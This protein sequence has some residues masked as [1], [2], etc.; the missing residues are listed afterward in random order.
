MRIISLI[1][2]IFAVI[3]IFFSCARETDQKVFVLFLVDTMRYDIFMEIA[4]NEYDESGFSYLYKNGSSFPLAFAPSPWT[5]PSFYSIFTA[6]PPHE[7]PSIT[8][9]GPASL[10]FFTD[11]LKNYGIKTAGFGSSPYF[12]TFF[13]FDK[14]FDVFHNI[15]KT[16]QSDTALRKVAPDTFFYAL[17]NAEE[18]KN[19]VFD[20]LK[21]Y[22]DKDCL[23]LFIHFIDP[24]I[25][26]LPIGDN[27][28][29]Y[30]EMSEVREFFIP[31]NLEYLRKKSNSYSGKTKDLI[32]Q[33]YYQCARDVDRRIYYI[34]Q[35]ITSRYGDENIMFML[36]SD[37]GEEF[38]EHGG[39]EHGHCFY[40]EVIHVPLVITDTG[41]DTEKPTDITYISRYIYDF[42]QIDM[43][44]HVPESIIISNNLYNT[45]G[46]A[47]IDF[48]FKFIYQ[49]NALLFNISSD[50][51]EHRPLADNILI[52]KYTSKAVQIL[53]GINALDF[54]EIDDNLRRDLQS[55]GYIQ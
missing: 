25:P 47:I 40:N 1:C 10:P 16:G 3:T 27:L 23:F 35:E 38:W 22:N 2:L 41:L 31:N 52:D 54:E 21:N 29:N 30:N 9:A 12:N 39:F 49:D 11:I 14:H 7:L 44:V 19:A 46:I 5:L 13:G 17:A 20:Y 24:H 43:E 26:Y 34:I 33:L 8:N 6:V 32:K 48:P 15:T 36:T 28:D 50:F 51:E 18:I 37:H 55:L 4:Q 53:D 45:P 42:F